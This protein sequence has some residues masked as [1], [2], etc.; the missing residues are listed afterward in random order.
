MTPPVQHVQLTEVGMRDG[1]Q[2]ESHILPTSAKVAVGEALLRAGVS[3]LEATSFVSPRAVPQLADAAIV[4]A[5]LKGRGAKIAALVPNRRGALRAA[6]ADVD[7]MV[8]FISASESH[9]RANVN[10]SIEDSLTAL[11]EV[12]AVS[13]E[14]GVVL[15]GAVAT[16]FGCPFEGEVSPSAVLRVLERYAKLG[17]RGVSLGDT[18]GMATPPTIERLLAAIQRELPE[19]QLSLHFHNTRG[20]GLV[21]VMTGL[22]LG[23]S[24]YESSIGGLGGCPFALGATGNV[25]SEDLVYMLDELGIATGIELESLCT[26]A[27]EVE[28]LF[29]RSLPGQVMKAGPRLRPRHANVAPK[30]A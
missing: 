7:E 28:A 2:M 6:E 5:A 26:V 12:A 4:V 21:N 17:V 29:G 9:N 30:C 27:S 19:L 25:C 18:T 24:R 14:R 15:C 8:V 1:F 23:I 20:L 11:T 10:R 22:Q 16:A 13:N 3:R